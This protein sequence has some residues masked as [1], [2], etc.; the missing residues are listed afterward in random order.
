MASSA[1]LCYHTAN[2]YDSDMDTL[3]AGAWLND[4]ILAF[5]MESV[6]HSAHRPRAAR[7]TRRI[8]QPLIVLSPLLFCLSF[9]QLSAAR[10]VC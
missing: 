5:F 1:L 3:K 9:A 4:N 10:C 2:V 8:H 6:S 7:L